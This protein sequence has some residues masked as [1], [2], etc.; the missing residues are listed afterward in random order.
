MLFFVVL[1]IFCGKGANGGGSGSGGFVLNLVEVA[2]LTRHI[3][4]IN[5]Y[6]YIYINIYIYIYIHGIY[7]FIGTVPE[8]I[9]KRNTK[10]LEQIEL[11][12]IVKVG[13]KL[14]NYPVAWS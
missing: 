11:P 4:Y 12:D 14:R 3:V 10:R 7:N 1:S 6:I 5:I 13:I 2:V 9:S 8:F